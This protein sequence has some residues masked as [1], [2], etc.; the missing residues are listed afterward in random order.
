[1]LSDFL[2]YMFISFSLN[3]MDNQNYLI[4][5]L[6]LKDIIATKS[7]RPITIL[8]LILKSTKPQKNID[9][10]IRKILFCLISYVFNVM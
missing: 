2:G 1:M 7:R 9:V 8:Y 10:E 6:F 3:M 4:F 5:E